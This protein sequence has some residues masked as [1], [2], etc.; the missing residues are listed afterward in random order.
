MTNEVTAQNQNRVQLV[1]PR[2]KTDYNVVQL[3]DVCMF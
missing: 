1:N 2:P 3:N